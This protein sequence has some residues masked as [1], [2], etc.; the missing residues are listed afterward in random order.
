MEER[1]TREQRTAFA[2]VG[3]KIAS[4]GMGLQELANN[5]H[6]SHLVV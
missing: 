3:A 4:M 5:A 2:K 6:D 1:V